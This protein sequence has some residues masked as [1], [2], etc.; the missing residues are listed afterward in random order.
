M[1]ELKKRVK[2]FWEAEPCGS[3]YGEAGERRA[4]FRQIEERR[5]ALEPYI[6]DFARFTEGGGLRVLEIGVG[7]GSDHVRWIANGAWAVGTDLTDAAARMTRENAQTR[8]M[9]ARL[10]VGDAERLPLASA[11]FDLVYSW[12]VL[13]HS[14]DTAAALEEVYRVLRPGG[15]ARLMVYHVPSW[16]AWMLWVRHGLLR[17][18]PTRPVRDI[19]ARHLESPGTKAYSVG[20]FRRLL[21]DT[22]FVD[23]ALSTHLSTSDLLLQDPSDRYSG[24]MYRAIWALYP[25]WLVRRIG[26]ALGMVLM[27]EAKRPDPESAGRPER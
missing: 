27:A 25:R 16:S 19:L 17:G 10:F 11:S 7:A 22:G 12:G 26:H 13:H 2:E 4:F 1:Q 18:R 3:R 14:P 6:E 23:P 8:G 21:A 5:Y 20:E 9:S 15:T 24:S